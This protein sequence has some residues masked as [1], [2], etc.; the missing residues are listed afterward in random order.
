MRT[1]TESTMPSV[2]VHILLGE[3]AQGAQQHHRTTDQ[4][5]HAMQTGFVLVREPA[6][7]SVYLIV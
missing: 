5:Q 3:L 7:N 2:K 1:R 6:G 4:L